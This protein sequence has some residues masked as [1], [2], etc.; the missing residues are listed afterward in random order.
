MAQQ[1]VDGDVAI[2]LPGGGALRLGAG[3]GPPEARMVLNNWRALRR[4]VLGGDVGFALG[5]LGGDWDT[6]DLAA[7]LASFARN[8]DALDGIT[9]GHPLLTGLAALGHALNR[10]SR[11]GSRRNILAHYDLG[12]DFYAAWLDPGMTYSS[13][14]GCVEGE[15]LERAQQRKYAALAQAVGVRRDDEVLEVGCGWG[16]FAAYLAGDLGARVTA[17]TLSPSQKAFAERRIFEAGLGERVTVRLC[18]YRDIAGDYDHIVSIEMLEAVGEAYWPGYFAKLEACLRPG[19]RLGLQVI[20]IEDALYDAYR[21]RPDFIQLQVFPGGMLPTVGRLSSLPRDAGLRPVGE[22]RRFGQDYAATL[23]QWRLA[24]E[25]AWPQIASSGFDER[26]RRL[27]RYYLA[28]CEAGF[29]TGR[30]DVVQMVL[31]RP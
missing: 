5:Y 28:Y 6:P 21:R 23:R 15:P 4:V 12:N 8:Y 18:D 24:F 3:D 1:W 13:G 17:I 14:L 26:F 27:W 31:A 16:G 30:T 20:T 9:A 2:E 19:G 10:N 29:R 7:L 11:T 22:L 25:A